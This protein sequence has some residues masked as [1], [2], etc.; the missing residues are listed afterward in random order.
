MSVYKSTGSGRDDIIVPD[1]AEAFLQ[2]YSLEDVQSHKTKERGVWVTYEDRV[3][4]ITEFVEGHPGG[5]Y[6]YIIY[7]NMIKIEHIN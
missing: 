3:Y 1:E 6:L 7:I 5:K 2:E 4:D